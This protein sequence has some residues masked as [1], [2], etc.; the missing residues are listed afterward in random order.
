M[1]APFKYSIALGANT[2]DREQN[3]Q[4]AFDFLDTGAFQLLKRSKL[5]ETEPWGF[6]SEHLFMNACALVL[7]A[8]E[9]LP[10][11]EKL[12]QFEKGLGRYKKNPGVYTDR[13]ID[14][15]IVAC[16]DMIFSD[17]SL[18]IPH[19]HLHQRSFVLEPLKEIDPAWV[20]PV[21]GKTPA[22]LL[23]DLEHAKKH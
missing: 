8:L 4:K 9:P 10:V 22:Q 23:A 2:G 6:E 1:S 7:T 16:G 21:L 15:D 3:L 5:Y 20:H 18:V 14:L 11:L 12:K 17:P 13:P 19:P